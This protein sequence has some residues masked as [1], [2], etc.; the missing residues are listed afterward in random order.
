MTRDQMCALLALAGW[1]LW[2]DATLALAK[3]PAL[4][5]WLSPGPKPSRSVSSLT[6]MN[7]KYQWLPNIT[8]PPNLQER[9]LH[10]APEAMLTKAVDHLLGAA[11]EH[12]TS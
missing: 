4:P 5:W 12:G 2:Y 1:T 6:K 10:C 11:H 9:P 3:D 7:R 8:P